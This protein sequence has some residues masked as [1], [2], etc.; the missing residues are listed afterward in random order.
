MTVDPERSYLIETCVIDGRPYLL[1]PAEDV[2]VNGLA[3]SVGLRA[4]L[5]CAVVHGAGAGIQRDL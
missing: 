4:K 5:S 3:V 2:E 1:I